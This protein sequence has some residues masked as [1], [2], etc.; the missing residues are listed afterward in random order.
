[1]KIGDLEL[2]GNVT[3]A[4]MAGITDPPFR[5]AVQRFG[6]SALW[7]EMMSAHALALGKLS[8]TMDLDGHDVPTVFQIYGSDPAIMAE[9][10]RIAQDSGASAVDINMGCPVKKIVKR[11]A[12]AALMKDVPLARRI[13]SA[14]RNTLRV[15]MTVKIRAGWDESHRNAAY[16][17]RLLE[18]EGADAVVVHA[19]TRSKAHSGPVSLSVLCEVREAVRI[20][21]IGNGGI[22]D[23]A[24][25]QE[26]IRATG[27]D[28]VMIG[29][30]ALGKP[31]LPGEVLRGLNGVDR[32]SQDEPS[33]LEVVMNHY[34]D[35][36]EW[37]DEWT[38]V[39]RMRKH[40]G[41]YSK[42][43]PDSTEFRRTVCR[44][45]EP[46]RI[47]QA[48]TDYFSPHISR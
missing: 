20:P 32:G 9:A 26:T 37:I 44:M 13:V 47:L 36:L 19:R 16:L 22:S 39:R 8:R 4:P 41:W 30:G 15:P 38:A 12:G 29:R 31:W 17:A 1:M 11:G 23:L 7:T 45:E 2:E 46:Q 34:L 42:G 14:L 24:A 6:V 27:C 40:L 33:V 28:G 48:I 35:Q 18:Q 5:R 10:G 43:F 21:V 3:L 25:A